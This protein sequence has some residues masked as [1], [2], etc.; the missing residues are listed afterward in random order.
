MPSRTEYLTILD[1]ILEY[2]VNVNNPYPEIDFAKANI[3]NKSTWVEK[4]WHKPIIN[5]I[6][7]TWTFPHE[8]AIIVKNTSSI[9]GVKLVLKIVI[10]GKYAWHKMTRKVITILTRILFII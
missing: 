4:S 10:W 8:N 5:P 9:S 1:Q 2:P 6:N 7:I 3:P